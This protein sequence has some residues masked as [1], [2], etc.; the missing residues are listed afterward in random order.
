MGRLA[1]WCGAQFRM[2]MSQIGLRLQEFDQAVEPA[3]IEF[4]GAANFAGD[5]DV[6]AGGGG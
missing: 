5:G 2:A 4:L 3:V 1:N 6:P